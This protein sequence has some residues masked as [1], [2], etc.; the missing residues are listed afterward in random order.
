MFIVVQIEIK[1]CLL[2]K[3]VITTM[4][5]SV[6]TKLSKYG[7]ELRHMIQQSY[8]SLRL[9]ESCDLWKIIAINS[10]TCTYFSRKKLSKY[11]QLTS[12]HSMFDVKTQSTLF[13]Y[14]LD[15]FES[16][17]YLAFCREEI[18]DDARS[19]ECTW[20]ITNTKQHFQ[21]STSITS[22]GGHHVS[23][24]DDWISLHLKYF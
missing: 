20:N 21:F 3:L 1:A 22:G 7:S 11:S 15:R 24:H 8:F 10:F 18:I 13:H 14:Y 12:F 16:S 5:W 6:A 4:T 2:H 19:P 23:P 9:S 17:L